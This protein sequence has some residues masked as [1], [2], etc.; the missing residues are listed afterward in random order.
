[1][2]SVSGAGT[3]NSGGSETIQDVTDAKLS[4]ATMQVNTNDAFSGLDAL[5][6]SAFAVGSWA[7]TSDVY[8]A[9]TEVNS[10]AAGTMPSH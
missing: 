3:I 9:S 5:D 7:A 1:M 6:L 8:D 2:T 10:E 4:V